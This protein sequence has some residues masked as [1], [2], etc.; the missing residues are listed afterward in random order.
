MEHLDIETHDHGIVLRPKED[1][2]GGDETD[3]VTKYV[4]DALDGGT[5]RVVLDFAR[6]GFINS[7]GLGAI[8]ACHVTVSKRGGTLVLCNYDE[9]I[10]RILEVTRLDTV[11]A[12]RDSVE[13][14]LDG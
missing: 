9:R 6:V 14:A 4:R 5:T 3:A 10:R 1:L 13:A 11:L 2:T 8:I 12:H 7:L